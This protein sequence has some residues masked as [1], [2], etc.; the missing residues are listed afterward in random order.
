ME[1]QGH[2]ETA[3]HDRAWPNLALMCS[4]QEYRRL[5]E[6]MVENKATEPGPLPPNM[7]SEQWSFLGPVVLDSVPGGA[8]F[9]THFRHPLFA[10]H[11]W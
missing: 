7:I 1:I 3:L 5:A 10:Y 8:K 11:F 9:F 2:H 6:A 4:T